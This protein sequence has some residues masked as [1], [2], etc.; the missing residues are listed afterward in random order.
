MEIF[1]H[2]C[3][4]CNGD[5]V[6]TASERGYFRVVDATRP[7]ESYDEFNARKRE[8]RKK[9]TYLAEEPHKRFFCTS[10]CYLD[11]CFVRYCCDKSQVDER[12]VRA[13]VSMLIAT[14]PAVLRKMNELFAKYDSITY[15]ASRLPAVLEFA[16]R[17]FSACVDQATAARDAAAAEIARENAVEWVMQPETVVTE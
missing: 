5:V 16:A 4:F 9:G 7:V 8:A 13:N 17:Q 2:A 10:R 15:A 11:Y 12:E 14:D 1:C 3:G 6:G